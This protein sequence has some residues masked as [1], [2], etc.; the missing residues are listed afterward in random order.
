MQPTDIRLK[1]VTRRMPD[2]VSDNGELAAAINMAND[3]AALS[4]LEQPQ[5]IFE[6]NEGETLMAIHRTATYYHYIIF[7]NNDNKLKYIDAQDDGTVIDDTRNDITTV[8]PTI[9]EVKTMGNT[10]VYNDNTGINYVLWRMDDEQYSVLGQKPPQIDIQFSLDNELRAYPSGSEL[11]LELENKRYT[12][13]IELPWIGKGGVGSTDPYQYC[14]PPQPLKDRL[15]SDEHVMYNENFSEFSFSLENAEARDSRY[16]NEVEEMVD[17]ITQFAMAGANKFVAEQTKKN[18]FVFPFFIRYAYELYDGSTIMASYPTL[19]VPNSKAPVFG[20]DGYEGLR[21]RLE[22]VGESYEKVS[23]G[24]QGRVYG[25]A[26]E[27]YYDIK[28]VASELNNWK[29]IVRGV[30]IYI[31]PQVITY[32]QQGKVYGWT[33]M[34]NMN[35]TDREKPNTGE[36]I[37]P[38]KKYYAMGRVNPT[39]HSD[40][41]N[42]YTVNN[43][44]KEL[45]A[46]TRGYFNHNMLDVP[47]E[48]GNRYFPV[49]SYKLDIPEKP[50]AKIIEELAASGTFFMV[51]HID[52]E[53]LRAVRREMF[54]I[55][56]EEGFIDTL[57]SRQTL[58]DDF[59]TRDAMAANV[60]HFYNRRLYAANISRTLHS[61]LIPFTQWQR[62]D[63]SRSPSAIKRWSIRVFIKDENGTIVLAKDSDGTDDFL[64]AQALPKFLF[65]PNPNAYKM[66]LSD[67]TRTYEVT[68]K[69]HQALNGAYWMGNLWDPYGNDG[70][71]TIAS[72]TP[73]TTDNTATSEGEV[74]FSNVENPFSFNADASDKVGEGIVLALCAAV[75]PLSEGQ[76]GQ[77]PLYAFTTQGVWALTMSNDGRV[78]TIQAVTRDIIIEGTTPLSLDQSVVYTTQRG[79]MM[80]TGSTAKCI[81]ETVDGMNWV[82]PDVTKEVKAVFGQGND[83]EIP[84]TQIGEHQW[85]CAATMAYDYANQRVYFTPLG[86]QF[87]WV[88]NIKTGLWTHT[89]SHVDTMV[90]AYPDC[91]FTQQ[92]VVVRM[93]RGKRYDKA[94]A[95][96]RPIKFVTAAHQKIMAL[97]VQGFVDNVATA[98]RG[99]RDW[100]NYPVIASSTTSHITRRTGTP[101]KAHT[102]TLLVNNDDKAAITSVAAV[103]ETEHTDKLR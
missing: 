38:W 61:P 84:L 31:T 42:Y 47:D 12:G 50:E 46:D 75:R 8:T 3:G 25:F 5:H 64:Y 103:V 94:V 53:E 78:S 40:Q 58:K 92:G 81:T 74:I 20:L 87:S 95:V 67:G 80:L 99:T 17:E 89:Q 101:Y 76:F 77:F 93:E 68:L 44:A 98:L 16:P 36:L 71:I 37:E 4:M 15:Q 49:P 24:F 29:D 30:N 45:A 23:Y 102:I 72:L 6:L 28:S 9:T 10:I 56:I 18:R 35:A 88:F 26:S 65:Y 39:H 11:Y 34:D 51:K 41:V 62:Q 22:D 90:N 33:N 82:L 54:D 57:E 32:D 79:V 83:F 73:P 14:V 48:H 1:G 52:I 66:Q 27:L 55:D 70:A 60:L 7:D 59:F 69:E 100:K 85:G 86:K 91:M 13:R 43:L 97:A 19:M 21:L 63:D 2:N 96:T